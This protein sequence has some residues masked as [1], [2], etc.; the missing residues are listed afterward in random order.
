MD[1]VLGSYDVGCSQIYGG[2][3]IAGSKSGELYFLDITTGKKIWQFINPSGA[4]VGPVIAD[5]VMYMYG[6]NNK[7]NPSGPI[8][9]ANELLMLTPFGK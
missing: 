7:W 3:V 8:K 2:V 4:S 1:R 6:G 9:Y 5:G